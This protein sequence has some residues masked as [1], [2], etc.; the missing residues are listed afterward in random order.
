MYLICCLGVESCR[1]V[2]FLMQG[3]RFVGTT[4]GGDPPLGIRRDDFSQ[5]ALR[6]HTVGRC[7]CWRCLVVSRNAEPPKP[8]TQNPKPTV[9]CF[10]REALRRQPLGWFLNLQPPSPQKMSPETPRPRTLGSKAHKFLRACK[11]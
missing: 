10:Y 11:S 6:H 9:I 8:Y 5:A 3:V 1:I 2:D 4:A 7:D